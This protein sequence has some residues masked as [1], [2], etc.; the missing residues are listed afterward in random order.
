[1]IKS[2]DI[3]FWGGGYFLNT[4]KIYQIK[5]IDVLNHLS[6][7]YPVSKTDRKNCLPIHVL[8]QTGD[9]KQIMQPSLHACSYWRHTLYKEY[10]F[11]C[12]PDYDKPQV[13]TWFKYSILNACYLKNHVSIFLIA[14]QNLLFM[15]Y[16]QKALFDL[17]KSLSN[18]STFWSKSPFL[19]VNMDE[20]HWFFFP[21]C[22]TSILL[23]VS[24]M[25]V[26]FF[27]HNSLRRSLEQ[28]TKTFT[29]NFEASC[30]RQSRVRIVARPLVPV[31]LTLAFLCVAQV[32]E[33][34]ALPHSG[35][36][37]EAELFKEVAWSYKKYW[38]FFWL[39]LGFDV[40]SKSE[41]CMCFV[42]YIW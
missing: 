2:K 40:W 11:T 36:V 16:D 22:N 39:F 28:H 8:A 30:G 32:H 34:R 37:D 31:T 26:L 7:T 12:L 29:A 9:L 20:Y 1:M 17:T 42:L 38:V 6:N 5:Y 15:A 23:L 10:L 35:V 21:I 3:F 18:G 19:Y 33:D 4:L 41:K 25:Y 14:V 24:Y 13:K 27:L